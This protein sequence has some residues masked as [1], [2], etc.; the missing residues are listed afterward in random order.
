MTVL[1][2]IAR[3]LL[4][5]IFISG[6]IDALRNPASKA[7]AAEGVAP[8]FTEAVPALAKYDTETLVR[9]NA[10]VQ[11][12]AG[13]MLALGRF[14]RLSAVAL[15][16]SV[17]P[18]TAAGHRFWENDEPLQR[19]QQRIHF[20]KNASILGGLLLAAADTEGKPGLSWRARHGASHAEA[21]VERGRRRARR[22]LDTAEREAK[23]VTKTARAALPGV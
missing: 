19:K 4:A 11:V 9:I 3:P 22:A 14:P 7:S 2:R 23:L 18:T 13:S 6:G 15:A 16:A 17:V 8:V 1:R 12:A 21:A 5:S 20:L 10:G